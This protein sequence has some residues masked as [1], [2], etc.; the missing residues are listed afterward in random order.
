MF[1]SKEL[2]LKGIK[3]EERQLEKSERLAFIIEQDNFNG[4]PRTISDLVGYELRKKF[5]N[6]IL[7]ENVKDLKAVPNGNGS[8]K[9]TFTY[10]LFLTP[11]Y[12]GYICGE[13]CHN[14]GET[15]G[16]TK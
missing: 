7:A 13:G 8:R 11:I 6:R 14:T 16:E 15:T 4:T 5:G 1:E 3:V 10:E 9:V 2:L 12:D